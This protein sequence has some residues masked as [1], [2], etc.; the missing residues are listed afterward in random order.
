MAINV[1]FVWC[2]A[3]LISLMH[4]EGHVLFNRVS[5]DFCGTLSQKQEC[6]CEGLPLF[7]C[8]PSLRSPFVTTC[9]YWSVL[10]YEYLSL[11]NIWFYLLQFSIVF[12][13]LLRWALS[14]LRVPQ[15]LTFTLEMWYFP[16]L[17]P[18]ITLRAHAM[19]ICFSFL[20]SALETRWE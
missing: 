18:S 1:L 16:P 11:L 12:P 17:E 20:P 5:S 8:L 3:V 4:F 19:R 13:S 9:F 6:E 7:C 15:S 14:M 10:H 2:S